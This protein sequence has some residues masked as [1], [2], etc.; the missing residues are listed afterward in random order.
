MFA[1]LLICPTKT[2]TSDSRQF[3][4]EVDQI[5]DGTNGLKKS[6]QDV[7]REMKSILKGDIDLSPVTDSSES[8]RII[9]HYQCPQETGTSTTDLISEECPLDKYLARPRNE[10]IMKLQT[11]LLQTSPQ[12]DK[13]Q[14]IH[15]VADVLRKAQE[16]RKLL[17]ENVHNILRKRKEMNTFLDPP[18]NEREASLRRIQKA[19]DV[20]IMS[21]NQDIEATLDKGL[22]QTVKPD[23]TKTNKPNTKS[24]KPSNRIPLMDRYQMKNT[25]NSNAGPRK[26]T[27]ATRNV[28]KPSEKVQPV[29]RK[30]KP[31]KPKEPPPASST[32][33][34]DLIM[35]HIY[36]RQPQLPARRT[37]KPKTPPA[38]T[39]VTQ[40]QPNLQPSQ[41]PSP[42]FYFHARESGKENMPVTGD[43]FPVAIPLAEPSR[44][45]TKRMPIYYSEQQENRY[46]DKPEPNIQQRKQ[47][48]K[49]SNVAVIEVK[50]NDSTESESSSV[51]E[52]IRANLRK[53][54][55]D[56]I[57][58][59]VQPLP[60]VDIDT[61]EG[62]SS[63]TLISSAFE[64]PNKLHHSSTSSPAKK[65]TYSPEKV[66]DSS[67]KKKTTFSPE[68]I[69][70]ASPRKKTP[71]SSHSTALSPK[72]Y[73]ENENV[74]EDEDDYDFQDFVA[75]RDIQQNECS[76]DDQ[77][78]YNDGSTDADQS[79]DFPM[80]MVQGGHSSDYQRPLKDDGPPFPPRQSKIP[81]E[82]EN[83]VEMSN[84]LETRAQ[85]WLENELLAKIVSQFETQNPDPT[86]K[87]MADNASLSEVEIESESTN[88]MDQVI[89]LHGIQLFVDAGVPIDKELVTSLVRNVIIERLESLYGYPQPMGRGRDNTEPVEEDLSFQRTVRI[90][91]PQRT[92][93]SSPPITSRAF[94]HVGTPDQSVGS[95]VEQS[96]M[97]NDEE[98]I[99]EIDEPTS[100]PLVNTPQ[101]SERDPTPVANVVYPGN[102]MATPVSSLYENENE[103]ARERE[104]FTPDR[105][106]VDGMSSLVEQVDFVPTSPERT[107]SPE[108]EPIKTP[109]Q[110]TPPPIHKPP[111]PVPT[112]T[113]PSTTQQTYSSST[114][115]GLSTFE[116]ISDGEHLF[117]SQLASE[118]EEGRGG[119]EGEPT[120]G[121]LHQSLLP[122][123]KTVDEIDEDLFS[124]EQDFGDHSDLKDLVKGLLNHP[125]SNRHYR[126]P[127][128]SDG[129]ITQP[130]SFSIGE[131]PAGEKGY[132]NDEDRTN[133]DDDT[134]LEDTLNSVC[135]H[136]TNKTIQ[137]STQNPIHQTT[138]QPIAVRQRPLLVAERPQA[139]HNVVTKRR[140]FSTEISEGEAVF[141][142]SNGSREIEDLLSLGQLDP[143]LQST[144][145]ENTLENANNRDQTNSV[146][147]RVLMVQPRTVENR[148]NETNLDNSSEG[149]LQ[150]SH[151]DQPAQQA[152]SNRDDLTSLLSDMNDGVLDLDLS[153]YDL[154]TLSGGEL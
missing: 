88:W 129:E 47:L 36:G 86:L 107:M 91:T 59:N 87:E 40:P 98:S 122:N 84:H 25:R 22:K 108:D 17:D 112:P 137:K 56:K 106:E 5:L 109:T 81:L 89:G 114:A 11:S 19:V 149:Q 49:T 41:L 51:R 145:N 65:T 12:N 125:P 74:G 138:N 53:R 104:V 35:R 29:R 99:T 60:N 1:N 123:Y 117:P 50:H 96:L 14:T 75:V 128:K 103:D 39:P 150:L 133:E 151:L 127:L 90:Q 43:L 153:E 134:L 63:T 4:C 136:P 111:S 144:V 94:S 119:S 37:L 15:R 121:L 3:H 42:K 2:N 85:E 44:D 8:E 118:G 55:R 7:N 64:S 9:H 68:K 62:S 52:K 57:R 116:G 113:T 146:T 32:A 130:Q 30:K 48:S 93:V 69:D 135:L 154:S 78:E 124:Y 21:I 45:P 105:T 126:H 31:E 6:L 16:Q 73:P 142:K 131:I 54:V 110:K 58:L 141:D 77:T 132:G 82:R 143:N 79:N 23:K 27:T 61:S 24:G 147:P 28:E 71:Y 20:E 92:P 10:D 152:E 66:N 34:D 140:N 38:Q 139:T 33:Y 18:N 148:A 46:T 26:T 70:H 67:P 83:N 72:K 115:V 101:Q 102:N 80:T 95:L 76:V 13:D 100:Y 120:A 97:R